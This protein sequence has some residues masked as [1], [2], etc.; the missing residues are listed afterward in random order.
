MGSSG[1]PFT[2]AP[3]ATVEL[4]GLPQTQRTTSRLRRPR[5]TPYGIQITSTLSMTVIVTCK[6]FRFHTSILVLALGQNVT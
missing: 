4:S 3:H 2:M 1:L 5:N 6:S